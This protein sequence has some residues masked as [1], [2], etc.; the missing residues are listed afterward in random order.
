MYGGTY[1]KR[2]MG[3]TKVRWRRRSVGFYDE[4][5]SHAAPLPIWLVLALGGANLFLGGALLVHPAAATLDAVYWV[6]W[7]WLLTAA[8]ALPAALAFPTAP[9]RVSLL[10]VSVVGAVGAILVLTPAIGSSPGLLATLAGVDGV[11]IGLAITLAWFR[12]AGAAAGIMG[13]VAFAVGV[14][15]LA[16]PGMQVFVLPLSMG[17]VATLGGSAAIVVAWRGRIGRLRA[18]PM[19][20]PAGH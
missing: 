7:L 19:V 3:T 14:L 4:A 11:L 13:V 18:R 12:G 15:L 9:Y 16:S 10:F 17:I 1:P 20:N 5:V 8:V 6:A 2:P